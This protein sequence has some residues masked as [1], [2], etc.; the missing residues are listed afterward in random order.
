MGERGDLNNLWKSF[1]IFL[2]EQKDKK[3]KE[4]EMIRRR[5]KFKKIKSKAKLGFF[6]S[7][8]L[9]FHLLYYLLPTKK[10]K[11]K[12]IIKLDQKVE[13]I[14]LHNKFE[15]VKD[16]VKKSDTLKELQ[17]CRDDFAFIH[18]K[19]GK[20]DT[21]FK[22]DVEEEIVKVDKKIEEKNPN[23]KE[24][25]IDLARV[26][27]PV[28][29]IAEDVITKPKKIENKEEENKKR[30]E[31]K[32]QEEKKLEKINKDKINQTKN[33]LSKAILY[34]N[35]QIE[36][37]NARTPK[38]TGKLSFF[39]KTIKETLSTSLIAQVLFRNPAITL[40]T[41]A[42]VVNNNIRSMRKTMNKNVKYINISDMENLKIQKKE[43]DR[44]TDKVFSNSLFQL[45]TFRQELLN[46][47]GKEVNYNNELT[48]ILKEIDDLEASIN[49]QK[50]Q[51]NIKTNNSIKHF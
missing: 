23:K 9:T 43:L 14:K 18:T 4:E 33:E 16:D 39:K 26:I 5:E 13:N 24:P 12:T 37:Q 49:M 6:I 29:A 38:K 15:K 25:E 21:K 41:S 28:V 27:V 50:E 30:K 34:I 2:K 32:K 1:R 47:Y 44:Y 48:S 7:L 3:K 17:K 20:K 45:S 35:K 19:I 31:E 40:F 22:K 36:L 11:N 46:K 10:E 51:I 8:T 42:I